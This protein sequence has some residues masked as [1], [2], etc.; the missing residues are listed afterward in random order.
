MLQLRKGHNKRGFYSDF[1]DDISAITVRFQRALLQMNNKNLGTLKTAQTRRK[2]GY[3]RMRQT[4]K[5][6]IDAPIKRPNTT[7]ILT[8]ITTPTSTHTCRQTRAH[9]H[10]RAFVW[11]EAFRCGA[12][13]IP[14]TADIALGLWAS[15]W[16]HKSLRK[17]YFLIFAATRNRIKALKFF[18][19]RLEQ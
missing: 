16:P 6:S 2:A 9:T 17:G 14:F 11:L 15:V 1:E 8:T 18:V 12:Q 7:P 4:A 10:R 13:L 5:P 3:H 19:S